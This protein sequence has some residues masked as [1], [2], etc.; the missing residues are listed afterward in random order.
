MV[1]FQLKHQFNNFSEYTGVLE[2]KGE[3]V[4]LDGEVEE[5][6]LDVVGHINNKQTDFPLILKHR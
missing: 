6:G 5:A 4:G 1:E 2:E 3:G